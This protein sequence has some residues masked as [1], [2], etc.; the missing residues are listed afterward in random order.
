M[1]NVDDWIRHCKF[2]PSIPIHDLSS[3]KTHEIMASLF[4]SSEVQHY[5][6]QCNVPR[7]SVHIDPENLA[8][9]DVGYLF[10]LSNSV[11]TKG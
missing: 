2:I 3:G 1:Y 4:V 6:C 5:C 7:E 9:F 11:G 10:P 8:V